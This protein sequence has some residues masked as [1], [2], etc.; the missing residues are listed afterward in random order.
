MCFETGAAVRSAKSKKS[1]KPAKLTKEKFVLPLTVRLVYRTK[2]ERREL[3]ADLKSA[4]SDG[5]TYA[6][7]ETHSYS[8]KIGKAPKVALAV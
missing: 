7:T 4:I 8:T 2:A 6:F 1:E 3:L 5:G